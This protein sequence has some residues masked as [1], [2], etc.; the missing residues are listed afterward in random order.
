M[1]R[2]CCEFFFQLPEETRKKNI[3]YNFECNCGG[4][5]SSAVEDRATDLMHQ[6][7]SSESR[8]VGPR[9]TKLLLKNVWENAAG[10]WPLASRRKHS[11]V[12][13]LKVSK[14]DCSCQFL[15]MRRLA[16]HPA[17]PV[18][19]QNRLAEALLPLSGNSS[20]KLCLNKK[21]Q[22][23]KTRTNVLDCF[24]LRV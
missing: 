4:T 20:V 22:L 5:C 23:I 13:S 19:E 21:L 3:Y 16:A 18:M 17:L 6:W 14:N 11:S 8:P 12:I 24:P 1:G 7:K 10:S 9:S 2:L 15:Q